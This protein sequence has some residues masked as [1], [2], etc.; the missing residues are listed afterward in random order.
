MNTPTPEIILL[1][2]QADLVVSRFL[3]DNFSKPSAELDLA[4]YHM[5]QAVE[6][7][8][9]HQI[10]VVTTTYKK[11]HDINRLIAEASKHNILVPMNIKKMGKNLKIYESLGRYNSAFIT[12]TNRL[13]EYYKDIEKYFD[14]IKLNG[15]LLKKK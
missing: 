6:K 4:A 7:L 13:Y 3:L 11:T 8:I 12:D 10:L 2:V 14:L 1:R 9:V 15:V 5:Q